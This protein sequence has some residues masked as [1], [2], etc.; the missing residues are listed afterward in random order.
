M[1]NQFTF[2]GM[3][4]V[5]PRFVDDCVTVPTEEGLLVDGMDRPRIVRAPGCFTLLPALISLMDGTNE[6]SDLERHFPQMDPEQVR[7]AASVLFSAGLL[8]D[9]VGYDE[10]NNCTNNNTLS[11][12]R[13]FLSVTGINS[14]AQEAY[15][16]L[17]NTEALIASHSNCEEASSRLQSSLLSV[18]FG[19]VRTLSAGFLNRPDHLITKMQHAIIVSLTFKG[20]DIDWNFKLDEWSSNRRIPWFRAVV[21]EKQH[22]ADIGPLFCSD[23][24]PCYQCFRL[25]HARPSGSFDDLEFDHCSST[26]M[27]W[28]GV[29]AAELMYLV[30]DISVAVT[31]KGFRRYDLRT[32]ESKVLQSFRLPGCA[33]CRAMGRGSPKGEIEERVDTAL[34]FEDYV[35][36]EVAPLGARRTTREGFLVQSMSIVE[37]EKYLR[38]CEQQ[39]LNQEYTGLD[40]NILDAMGAELQIS[41]KR[42][43]ASGIATILRMTAGIREADFA[44]RKVSRWAPTSG[45][46]GSVE[47]F[48]AI[49]EIDGLAPGFYFYHPQQHALAALERRGGSIGVDEF[50]RRVILCDS[51]TLPGVM[52]CLVGAF[53]RVSRKYG[54]FGYKLINLDA[55]VAIGRL[56]LTARSLGVSAQIVAESADDLV[57]RELSL[58]A[59]SR[60]STAVIA[61]SHGAKGQLDIRSRNRSGH[62]IRYPLVKRQPREFYEL[63]TA[64]VLEL[65]FLE[66]RKRECDPRG[67]R[68]EFIAERGFTAN[69]SNYGGVFLP[70]PARCLRSIGKVFGDRK[71]IR[72]YS[73]KSVP[74]EYISSIL[75]HACPD[76]RLSHSDGCSYT[77][78]LRF[79]LLAQHIEGLLPG[80]YSY[81]PG[82]HLLR[83]VRS[84]LSPEEFKQLV[85]QDEFGKAPFQIWVI[86][87][88][89]SVCESHGSIG[90][91]HL[92]LWGG[93]AVQRLS[94]VALGLGLGGAI[95]AGLVRGAARSLLGLDGYQQTGIVAFVGGF[96]DDV[97][98]H[99]KT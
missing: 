5:R 29:V 84:A 37:Q 55:G 11:F 95:V 91:R 8:E 33:R 90:H 70:P 58:N 32:L 13:R 28:T 23:K 85:V 6:I 87:D 47:V 2:Q 53:G 38:S 51:E 88:L 12:F 30:S 98:D 67:V 50:M 92:L 49:R 69:H 74:C 56:H 42:L 3:T 22:Y 36:L 16:K 64:D 62:S 46:L 40:C 9:N 19:A 82:H 86:G 39:P 7:R 72:K 60:Q 97:N 25:V 94:L 66:S 34:V 31:K 79:L 99:G 81:V 24:T 4:P 83:I 89:A 18:G 52:I 27:F 71:T 59:P 93:I 73:T 63:R 76:F 45:N 57:E 17:Q 54:P 78:S 35:G 96:A 15:S 77:Q 1:S 68:D 41:P 21:D 65:L 80:V 43:T 10:T 20:D 44:A 75:Y 48:L 61:L 14:S 26:H